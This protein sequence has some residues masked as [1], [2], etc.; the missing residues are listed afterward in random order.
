MTALSPRRLAATLGVTAAISY[1]TNYYAFG[2]LAPDIAGELGLSLTALYGLLSAA[3]GLGGLAAPRA[4]R[5]VDRLGGPRAMAWGSL[6]TVAGLIVLAASPGA[7]AFGVILLF[8]QAASTLVFYDAAFAV[9]TRLA[10]QAARRVI[11]GITLIAGFSS[12]LFWPLT[13]GLMD[14]GLGWRGI[15]FLY[16]LLNLVTCVPLHFMLAGR[17][18]AQPAA[19]DSGSSAGAAGRLGA[20]DNR[21][22]ALWLVALAFGLVGFTISGL[23][24]N[25]VHVLAGVSTAATAALVSMVIGPAQ[26][27]GR[28][29]E[30]ASGGRV[31]AATVTV[32]ALIAMAGGLA[33]LAGFPSTVP[34]MVAAAALYGAGQGLTSIARGT[35][36]LEL[37]GSDSYGALLGW[38]GRTYLIA[39]A[40]G[41]VTMAAVYER[42]G[43]TGFFGVL[44]ATCLAGVALALRLRSLR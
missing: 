42:L 32:I 35:L 28:L 41:P 26:V 18:A 38:L 39:N 22:V 4:G 23:L 16:A 7:A 14:L 37:F 20:G 30:Y 2:V 25:L 34:V 33:A 19:G 9:A 36:P 27:A 11:T 29:A 6:A 10:P 21:Q 24:S 31:S 3:V 5:L 43:A 15:Y 12:T 8:L 44:S 1:G 17:V 13:L 40:I